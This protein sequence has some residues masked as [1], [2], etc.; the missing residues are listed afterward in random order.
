[1]IHTLTLDL[2]DIEEQSLSNYAISQKTTSNE[3]INNLMIGVKNQ[4]DV[5][6]FNYIKR[7][8]SNID[9]KDALNLIY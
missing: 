4:I 3:I 6:L 1:M 2:T 5:Y 7:E 8:I 9:I